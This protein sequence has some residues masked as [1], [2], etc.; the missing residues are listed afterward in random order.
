MCIGL[1]KGSPYGEWKM[2]IHTY[3][4]HILKCM[5]YVYRAAERIAVWQVEE[6]GTKDARACCERGLSPKHR[7]HYFWDFLR[8][9]V[10][11][12]CVV[13]CS[14]LQ[15][16]VVCCSVLQC[17][18]VCCGVLQWVL[19]SVLQSV[20]QC[21]L[22]KRTFFD[23]PYDDW[24]RRCLCCS[25]LQCVAQCMLQSVLQCVLRKRAFTETS[26]AL[27]SRFATKNGG[28]YRCG[29]VCVAVWSSVCCKE[30]CGVCCSVSFCARG[31]SL[32]HP[33]HTFTLVYT[34]ICIYK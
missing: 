21:V 33:R 23:T 17:V 31:R 27:F 13:C 25:V 32:Q 19:Q 24:W 5:Y 30:C 14:V 7:W 8:R 28:A 22:W 1:L 2:L 18:A 6:H 15:C 12:V 26:Q 29:C 3:R 9:L 16:V 20:L 10:A 4:T 34:C 11:Q